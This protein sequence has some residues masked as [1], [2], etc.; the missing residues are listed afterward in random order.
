MDGSSV[1]L[2]IPLYKGVHTSEQLRGSHGMLQ[3]PPREVLQLINRVSQLCS[4]GYRRNIQ[5]S[6]IKS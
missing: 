6:L 5:R 4:D 2:Y 1:V 3:S